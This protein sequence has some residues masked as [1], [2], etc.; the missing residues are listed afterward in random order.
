MMRIPFVSFEKYPLCVDL[1]LYILDFGYYSDSSLGLV[2]L[3]G[4]FTN[5][6]LDSSYFGRVDN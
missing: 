3:N 2:H 6:F 1:S 5:G 4:S